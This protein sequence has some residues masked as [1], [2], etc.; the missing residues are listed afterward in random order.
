MI[1]S[2]FAVSEISMPVHVLP[3]QRLQYS[4]CLT[5]NLLP[6]RSTSVLYIHVTRNSDR[7]GGRG[8]VEGAVKGRIMS[9]SDTVC[10]HHH[11]WHNSPFW[12]KAFFRSFCQLSLFLAPFLQFLF[13]NF[14]ASSITPSSHLSF[15]LPL[16][17]LPSTTATRT[18]LVGLCSSIRITWP[19]HFNRLIL[20][21]VTTSLPLYNVY[22]SLLY[23]ILHFPL[24][25][26]VQ[27]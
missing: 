6:K 7:L 16:C 15:G 19:A 20:M 21:Y 22:N 23:F 27:K 9:I 2:P 12:A 5:R 3:R 13:P 25:F 24:S 17:L 14:L 4:K 11:H 10:H 8:G 18:L 1:A 26:V